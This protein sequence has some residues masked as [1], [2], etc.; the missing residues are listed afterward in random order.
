M[1]VPAANFYK[2][3]GMSEEKK[4]FVRYILRVEVFERENYYTTKLLCEEH[5]CELPI[6]AWGSLDLNI[7]AAALFEQAKTN[8]EREFDEEA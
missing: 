6:S 5:N 2:E 4:M 8:F 1:G 7:L 3:A